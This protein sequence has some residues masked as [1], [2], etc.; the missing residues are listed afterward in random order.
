[1]RNLI[2]CGC[3]ASFFEQVC[4]GLSQQ[5]SNCQIAFTIY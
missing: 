1:M 5:F 3:A 2:Y 4:K